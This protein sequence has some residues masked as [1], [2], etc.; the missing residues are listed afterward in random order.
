MSNDKHSKKFQYKVLNRCSVGN[1]DGCVRNKKW[2]KVKKMKMVGTLLQKG[3]KNKRSSRYAK[4]YMILKK[5][6]GLQ[7]ATSIQD[8]TLEINSARAV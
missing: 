2:V 5:E 6:N 1:I 8:F 4:N 3:I 7:I